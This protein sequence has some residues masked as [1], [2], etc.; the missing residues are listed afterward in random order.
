MGYLHQLHHRFVRLG[1][2]DKGAVGD[3]GFGRV[4]FVDIFMLI[5]ASGMLKCCITGVDFNFDFD[6]LRW[7][8]LDRSVKPH[9]E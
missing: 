2:I 3:V 8:Q 1:E 5:D 7:R 9:C 6:S 4:E